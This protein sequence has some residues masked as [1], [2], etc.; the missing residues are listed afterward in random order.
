VRYQAFKTSGQL[1]LLLAGHWLKVLEEAEQ[2]VEQSLSQIGRLKHYYNKMTITN[3]FGI[4]FIISI[5]MGIKIGSGANSLTNHRQMEEVKSAL[6]S[7]PRAPREAQ[8]TD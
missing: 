4:A 6:S 8:C 2:G 3:T 5:S 1:G 7:K